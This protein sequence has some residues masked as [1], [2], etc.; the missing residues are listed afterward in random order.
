MCFKNKWPKLPNTT[1]HY[2]CNYEHTLTGRGSMGGG[3]GG[4]REP[5]LPLKAPV[6]SH[7][8]CGARDNIY[9]S[10]DM[11]IDART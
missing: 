4:G 8:A 10:I 6:D 11:H 3:G 7:W 5:T 2:G 9:M 1:I